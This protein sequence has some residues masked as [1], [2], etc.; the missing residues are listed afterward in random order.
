MFFSF[1]YCLKSFT[2][3]Y[4]EHSR[5]SFAFTETM[6]K[7][8]ASPNFICCQ[9]SNDT[10]IH[11][12]QQKALQRNILCKYKN[13]CET[14]YLIT[15]EVG[16]VLFQSIKILHSTSPKSILKLYFLQIHSSCGRCSCRK[17]QMVHCWMSKGSKRV[18]SK[19][20]TFF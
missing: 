11:S 4:R 19:M 7:E 12:L 3:T 5:G 9:S 17:T 20:L 13:C 6:K 16:M 14:I 15:G 8:D 2:I 1:N 18:L 10:L